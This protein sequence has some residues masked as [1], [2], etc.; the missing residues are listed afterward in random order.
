[1]GVGASSSA[2]LLVGDGLRGPLP[3]LS[4]LIV[5]PRSPQAL[6]TFP[7][8]PLSSLLELR[9]GPKT[10]LASSPGLCHLH[11]SL[12]ERGSS[13]HVARG[14]GWCS[15]QRWVSAQV[16]PPVERLSG[17][18]VSWFQ[19][20]RH[21]NPHAWS[22]EPRRVREGERSQPRPVRTRPSPPPCGGRFRTGSPPGA[23]LPAWG[24]S[25]A[26]LPA[27]VLPAQRSRSRKGQAV[28]AGMSVLP[29]HG[30]V[31]ARDGPDPLAPGLTIPE[32]S[33]KTC[34]QRPSPPG[35]L[36]LTLLQ[37][38][39][40]Q[41]GSPSGAWGGACGG[42]PGS[43]GAEV[44]APHCPPHPAPGGGAPPAGSLGWPD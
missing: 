31:S 4:V 23:L 44:P 36:L 7:R 30:P 35:L 1:M 5:P 38:A 2:F 9:K 34:V 25:E 10:L 6:G 15:P 43:P 22:R 28:M 33:G 13:P 19:F 17:Y 16:T 3:S 14:P 27:L 11:G 21:D 8:R 20:H 29:C 42:A 26:A 41:R 37:Q 18:C 24:L 12:R 32:P 39:A 40:A